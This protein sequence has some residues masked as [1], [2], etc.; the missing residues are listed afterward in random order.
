MEKYGRTIPGI[1]Y[2]SVVYSRTRNL[3]NQIILPNAD[4]PKIA[5]QIT[6]IVNKTLAEMRKNLK[7][8]K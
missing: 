3:F 1:A 7:V 4:I 8:W 5:R 2:Q 6:D